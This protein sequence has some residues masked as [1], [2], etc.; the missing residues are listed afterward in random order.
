MSNKLRKLTIAGECV[1]KYQIVYNEK[2]NK[3]EGNAANELA[4]YIALTTGHELPVVT[5]DA[6][7]TEHEI[8]VGHT[9]RE[10]ELYTVDREK[11]EYEGYMIGV[12]GKKLVIAGHERR[13]T[14]YGVYDFLE[15]HLNWRFFV[16]GLELMRSEEDVDIPEGFFEEKLPVFEYR[17]IDWIYARDVVWAN[18][19]KLNGGYRRYDEAHGS[20]LPWGGAIHSLGSY[21][22]DVNSYKEQPCLSDPKNIEIVIAKIEKIMEEKPWIELFEI[23]QNDNQNYCKCER[24]NAIAEEEGNQA[25]VLI[26]FINALSDHFKDKYPKLHFQTFAYQYTRTAPK[27]TVP[28]D[29][30]VIK[31]CPMEC[32]YHH[33]L[34]ADCP[35]NLAFAS[36][37][38]SWKKA[39]KKIYI[40]DY[41]TNYSYFLAPFPNLSVQRKNVRWFAENNVKGLYPEGN[42][43]AP[44][45]EFAELRG[46]LQAKLMWDPYMSEEEYNYHM[47]DFLEGYYGAGWQEIKKF[48][49]FTERE[50]HKRH[51][52]LWSH[53]NLVIPLE[54]WKEN[55]AEIHTWWDAAEEAVKEDALRL[56]H[57]Q[58]SR[59]QFTFLEL[60]VTWEDRFE[61]K[62]KASRD[63]YRRDCMKFYNTLV[64]G[65]I[66]WREAY[67]YPPKV[68]FSAP[69]LSWCNA[70]TY[71]EEETE[72]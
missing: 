22:D 7:A 50:A 52:D 29:N 14:L 60:T 53:P 9:N 55:A 16:P 35:Q 36:D 56:E 17:D 12:Y 47:D 30:V 39:A 68:N 38:E 11:Y 28:R 32:C 71:G 46:Y 70:H 26:R 6:P 57:V 40:W 41:S 18:K 43:C 64:K 67:D 51:C 49:D 27:K 61:G 10:G 23:S 24:C 44:S 34:Y 54:V 4:K 8:I 20:N 42:Y 15:K 25:G 72:D 45:G 3:S 62:D 1:C 65:G 48:I 63:A 21:F 37:L 5:D 19:A 31:L 33:P 58:R 13:G 59:L 69:P 2:S 66:Y